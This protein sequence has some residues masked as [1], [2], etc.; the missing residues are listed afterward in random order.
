MAP[1][2]YASLAAYH[3]ARRSKLGLFWCI[4]ASSGAYRAAVH[5]LRQLA[6]PGGLA[7]DATAMLHARAGFMAQSAYEAMTESLYQRADVDEIDDHIACAMAAAT[8][9]TRS[10]RCRS[11]RS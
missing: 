5:E 4:L 1:S 6:L 3:R 7:K 9:S 10:R 8:Q 11:S 2:G